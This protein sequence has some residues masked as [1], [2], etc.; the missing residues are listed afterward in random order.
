MPCF[1]C[2]CFVCVW[3]FVIMIQHF[4]PPRLST[5]STHTAPIPLPA[6][7][8][9]AHT[10]TKPSRADAVASRSQLVELGPATCVGTWPGHGTKIEPATESKLTVFVF[11]VLPKPN[12]TSTRRQTLYLSTATFGP[13]PQGMLQVV[14]SGPSSY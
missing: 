8:V 4:F 10:Q 11:R 9:H 5:R 2:L 14:L 12:S 1:E 7:S 13:C 6:G 3:V